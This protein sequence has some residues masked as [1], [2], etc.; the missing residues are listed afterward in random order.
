MRDKKGGN[1]NQKH[2]A[3]NMTNGQN[4]WRQFN[5][6]CNKCGKQGHKAQDCRSNGE[7]NDGNVKNG[8]G[9]KN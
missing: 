5:G 4:S 2:L 7:R 1:Q 6:K 3:L 9:V 8:N